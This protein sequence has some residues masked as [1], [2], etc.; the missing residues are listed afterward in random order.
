[1][2]TKTQRNLF[3]N[4]QRTE[5]E[6]KMEQNMKVI[7]EDD[8]NIYV[9]VKNIK[10]R[11]KALGFLSPLTVM[12]FTIVFSIVASLLLIVFPSA[13]LLILLIV[14]SLSMFATMIFGLWFTDDTKNYKEL[15]RFRLPNK[16]KWYFIA[17]IAGIL[18]FAGLQGAAWLMGQMGLSVESSDTST[19]VSQAP[20]VVGI[21]LMAVFVPILVPIMEEIF[22]RGYILSTFEHSTENK[23]TGLKLGIIMSSVFFG[24]AH[25][26]FT[27]TATDFFIP[28]WT[29][30]LGLANALLVV[31]SN[32]IIPPILFHVFYNGITV[33]AMALL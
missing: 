12:A 2:L 8:E 29:G 28:L 14:T 11:R 27:G 7:K 6:G 31:K 25:I 30:L 3:A 9:K 23:N 33:L 13:T 32:S 1:M 4:N 21:I 16:K 22:Y 24:L 10:G 5:E 17:P 20:G 19:S 18:F 15:L 26:Q